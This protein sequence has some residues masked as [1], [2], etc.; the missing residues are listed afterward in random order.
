VPN[1]DLALALRGAGRRYGE[2]AALRD[3]SLEL[4]AGR[5][6]VV[7]GPNGAGKTTLLRML[8]T[9]LRPHAGDVCVLGHPLPEDGYAVRGRIGFLGHEPLLYREL[10]GRENLRFH[11]KLHRVAAARVD[12][13]LDAV[14]MRAR[15]SDPIAELSRGMIQRLA[16]ARAVLHEPDLLLLD[17]PL[18]NLDPAAAAQVAPLIGPGG[19][20]TRVVT[21]HD[22]AG[23]LK[24]ADLALGLKGG[25]VALLAPAADVRPEQIAELY[26]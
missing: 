25:R 19:G 6:L 5:T 21:S 8:A 4:Q 26:A 9:L 13:V 1:P 2:R 10:S 20:R 18:A 3:V 23:G 11:A 14:G 22:P 16:I 17:E 15:A 24:D 12:V 7:F